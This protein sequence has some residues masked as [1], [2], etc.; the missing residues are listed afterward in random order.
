ML[1][2]NNFKY[3]YFCKVCGKEIYED[4]AVCKECKTNEFIDVWG[5]SFFNEKLILL[6]V[7]GEYPCYYKYW[8]AYNKNKGVIKNKRFN[9]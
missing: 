9:C 1:T 5:N 7:V 2:I 8:E 6:E 4:E 3:L